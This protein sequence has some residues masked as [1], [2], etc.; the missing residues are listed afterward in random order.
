MGYIHDL[1]RGRCS[2]IAPTAEKLTSTGQQATADGRSN[3]AG[4]SG[5]D[6]AP[7]DFWPPLRTL[8]SVMPCINDRAVVKNPVGRPTG[9]RRCHCAIQLRSSEKSSRTQWHTL[10]T[11]FRYAII[12]PLTVKCRSSAHSQ[13][14]TVTLILLRLHSAKRLSCCRA[15]KALR[16]HYAT[17]PPVTKTTASSRYRTPIMFWANS[18]LCSDGRPTQHG[19]RGLTSMPN[20]PSPFIERGRCH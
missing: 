20:T 18:P 14:S 3:P 19:R 12:C 11:H 4:I 5:F 7:L 6:T 16:R 2:P 15:A 9:I 13:K 17:T 1:S 10:L 8:G